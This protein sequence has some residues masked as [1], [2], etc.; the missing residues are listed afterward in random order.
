MNPLRQKS[1]EDQKN[2]FKLCL[3]LGVQKKEK[4]SN[5]DFLFFLTKQDKEGN[6]EILPRSLNEQMKINFPK[7]YSLENFSNEFLSENLEARKRISLLERVSEKN[8]LI[9]L[10]EYWELE[11][12]EN[13]IDFRILPK[14][15]FILNSEKKNLSCEIPYL[16]EKVFLQN[17]EEISNK[18]LCFRALKNFFSHLQNFS[19]KPPNFIFSN[20]K[21]N[22]KLFEI[23]LTKNP[24]WNFISYLENF[25]QTDLSLYLYNE[26]L[27]NLSDIIEENCSREEKRK[28]HEIF[29]TLKE[30]DL[31]KIVVCLENTNFNISRFL[32]NF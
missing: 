21:G 22:E 18:I 25:E 20:Y 1:Y 19:F 7:S 3:N 24:I 14:P 6:Y 8:K 29:S 9:F 5:F 16:P 26:L 32:S 2:V 28:K 27:R 4:I 15:I 31:S 10:L 12:R 13:D 17:E 30:N 11:I 23:L